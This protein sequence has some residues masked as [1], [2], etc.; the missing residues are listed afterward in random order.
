MSMPDVSRAGAIQSEPRRATRD[1]RRLVVETIL[2]AFY[3]EPTVRWLFPEIGTFERGARSFF[4]YLFDRRVE[5]AEVWWVPG[6]AV[7][8]WE[9]PGGIVEGA[10][11]PTTGTAVAHMPE[12]AVAK[13]VLYNEAVGARIPTADAWYLGVLAVHP[14]RQGEGFGR[15]LINPV[16]N[17]ADPAGEP[18]ALETAVAANVGLYEYLGFEVI[19]HFSVPSGGPEVWIMQRPPGAGTGW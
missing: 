5:A 2:R 1:D 7:S 11:V 16:R 8:T 10:I 3:D 14:D 9:P 13:L 15:R 4:G 17:R 6:V 19:D 18:I 12:P